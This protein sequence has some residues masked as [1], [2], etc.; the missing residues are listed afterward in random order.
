MEE[1]E[2]KF[3]DINKQ[4]IENKLVNL[5][6]EKVL[7]ILYRRRVFDYS[8]LRL[9][10]DNS[11]LRLRDEGDK[12]TL[13]YKKRFGTGEKFKDEGMYEKEIVV[14]DVVD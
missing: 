6:A 7:D 2:V 5:G 8:D 13:T 9:S 3:L 14:S 1:I 4:E 12:V 11:W 10:E